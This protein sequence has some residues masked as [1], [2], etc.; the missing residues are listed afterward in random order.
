MKVSFAFFKPG[1]KRAEYGL[2]FEM[3]AVPQH[4]DIVIVRRPDTPSGTI[5]PEETFVVRRSEWLLGSP[6]HNSAPAQG[7]T[8]GSVDLLTVECEFVDPKDH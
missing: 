5:H 2:D 8:I 4:G 6:I 1:V 7:R 3:P